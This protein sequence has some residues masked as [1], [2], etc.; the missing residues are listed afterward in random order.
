MRLRFDE[1]PLGTR[2]KYPGLGDRVFVVIEQYRKESD[3]EPLSGTVAEWC[4]GAVK[5]PFQ[6]IFTHDP[7]E[8]GL[9]NDYEVVDHSADGK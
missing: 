7:T 3:S 2:F 1:M 9:P 8:E 4:Y 5:N 6:N